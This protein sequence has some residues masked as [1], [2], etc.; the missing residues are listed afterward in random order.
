MTFRSR[1]N[2]AVIGLIGLP[3]ITAR[4]S[5]AENHAPSVKINSPANN[6]AFQS[7]TAISY[8]ISVADK[9][10]GDTR[11]EEI[12]AKEV[13]LELRH[14]ADN[15]GL[16]IVLKKPAPEDA[17]GIAIMRRSNCFTCHNF[18]SKSIGPSF[19]EISIHYPPSKANGDSL[20]S[21]IRNGAGGIWG[22]EK[23]PSHPELTTTEINGIVQWIF[24]H[25]ANREISFYIGTSGIIQIPGNSRGS[26][27]LTAS[28]TDHGSKNGAGKHMRG[29]DRIAISIR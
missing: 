1:I 19:F 23:M 17:P 28:Y 2:I 22:K 20:A 4:Y 15:S 18:I 9:E 14:F 24:N 7:G 26:Y 11:Y 8:E 12:N 25:A 16:E 6:T 13:L 5:Q 10:D 27:L 21:R 29:N 3:A